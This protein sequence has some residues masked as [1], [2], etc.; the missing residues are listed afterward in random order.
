MKRAGVSLQATARPSSR[1]D[2]TSRRRRKAVR[3]ATTRKRMNRLTLPW[4]RSPMMGP[5]LSRTVTTRP[6]R[7]RPARRLDESEDPEQGQQGQADLE[8][9]PRQG[10]PGRRHPGHRV[11]DDGHDR[12]VG[13]VVRLGVAAGP[14][15]TVENVVLPAGEGAAVVEDLDAVLNAHHGEEGEEAQDEPGAADLDQP[16]RASIQRRGRVHDGASVQAR[17]RRGTPFPRT[18]RPL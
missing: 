15:E 17:E 8:V 7:K 3:A 9:E 4:C 18:G 10:A 16:D 13:I 1:P 2:R 5:R 12:R 14:V 6:E 11:E